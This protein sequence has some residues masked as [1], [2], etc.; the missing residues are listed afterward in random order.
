MNSV[1]RAFVGIVVIGCCGIVWGQYPSQNME[2]TDHLSLSQLGGGDGSDIWGWTD[3]MT[4]KEYALMARTNGMSFVDVTDPYNITLLGTLPGY[5]GGDNV[6]RDVKTY[7]NHAYIVADGVGPHGLQVFDLTQLRGVTTPQTFTTTYNDSTFRTAHNIVINEESGYAYA[8]GTNVAGGQPLAYDLSNPAAP[9]YVATIDVD[10]YSH[11]AQVVNYHGPDPDH[12]GIELMMSASANDLVLIDVTQKS[13][14]FRITEVGHDLA[15]YVHQGWLNDDHTIF[16]MNDELDTTWT[17]KWDVT[18]LD[19]PVYLGDIAPTAGDAIDHNLYV[20]GRYIFAANY[21]SGLRTF[22]FTD[23][24]TVNTTEV[25]YL[26]TY[27]SGNN[28]QFN[29]AWSTYPYFDSGNIITS[30]ING[31]LFVTRLTNRPADFDADGYM[32]CTDIDQLTEAVANQTAQPW[33]DLDGDGDLTAGDIE[34]W[35]TIAGEENIGRAYSPGDADLNGVV[36]TSD[37]NRWNANKFTTES[38]WCNGNFDGNGVVDASD[39]NIWNSRT[40]GTPVANAVPE[41]SSWFALL[42]CGLLCGWLRRRRR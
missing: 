5:D 9:A 30:D 24:P 16:F 2:L 23:L 41:P 15:A 42:S 28:Q 14:P 19:N 18:D 6:W 1:V 20:K 29:G 40:F 7:Q 25:A 3:P 21:E 11:D 38:G 26:D 39:F 36:D 4:N 8:V 32:D 10:G 34:S 27:P 31:G 33:F 13:N 37:F 35:L 22:E 12:Q 17:H